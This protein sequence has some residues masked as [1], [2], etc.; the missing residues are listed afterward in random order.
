MPSTMATSRAR[1]PNCAETGRLA[2]KISFTVRLRECMEGPKF[3]QRSHTDPIF[4][5]TRKSSIRELVGPTVVTCGTIVL[6]R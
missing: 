2:R 6:Y 4:T 5:L 1:T 3:I